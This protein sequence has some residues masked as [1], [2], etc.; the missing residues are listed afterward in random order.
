MRTVLLALRDD[1]EDQDD[2]PDSWSQR[3]FRFAAHL[4]GEERP[5]PNEPDATWDWIDR[6]CSR[7]AERFDLVRTMLATADARSEP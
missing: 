3:W 7:F 2:D 4:A 5:S 1:E 6:A